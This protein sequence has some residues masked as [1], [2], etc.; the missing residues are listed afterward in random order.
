MPER[1]DRNIMFWVNDKEFDL[2]RQ[3]MKQAGTA[4]MSAYLRKTAIDGY[5]VKLEI[6]ELQKLNSLLGRISGSINQIARRVNATSRIYDKDISE[7]KEMQKKICLLQ[8]KIVAKL[9]QYSL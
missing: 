1:R 2:I 8:G 9:L 3:K 4:N 7:I 6:P 5:I